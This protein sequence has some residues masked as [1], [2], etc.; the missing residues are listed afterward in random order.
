M[1]KAIYHRNQDEISCCQEFFDQVMAWAEPVDQILV[2]AESV[3][4]RN[5]L[6]AVDALHL[7]AA[8]ILG[9]E[10]GDDGRITQAAAPGHRH[11]DCRDLT[12]LR[13]RRWP[14]NQIASSSGKG[15]RS[16]T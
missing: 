3:A 5:G 8:F 6:N 1:P 2:R 15:S 12:C 14:Q 7:A 13:T 16:T 4:E 11:Q 10:E 9:A